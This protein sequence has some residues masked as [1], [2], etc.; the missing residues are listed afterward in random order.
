M[1]KRQSFYVVALFSFAM[2]MTAGCA[3]QNVVKKDEGIVPTSG[4]KQA[5]Q[6]KS[7]TTQPKQATTT[8]VLQVT[9]AQTPAPDQ[10]AQKASSTSQLRRDVRGH[11]ARTGAVRHVRSDSPVP[12][13]ARR[14]PRHA[15]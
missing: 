2:F 11:H 1:L 9:P 15:G 8:S 13:A 5:D 3:T 7:T 12:G 4:T 6:S 14:D 10:Q